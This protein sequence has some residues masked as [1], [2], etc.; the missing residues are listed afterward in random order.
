[1]VGTLLEM[2]DDI[3]YRPLGAYD[4]VL[5]TP[6][7][8]PLAKK[9]DVTLEDIATYGLIL[10]PRHLSSSRIVNLVFEQHHVPY[11]ITLE[12]G[13]WEVIKQFV[14]RGLGI[15]ICASLCLTGAEELVAIPVSRYFPRRNYGLIL[16]KGK[17]V[18][19]A[20][21]R[22][23]DMLADTKFKENPSLNNL[24]HGAASRS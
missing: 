12:A 14:A 10:P 4:P 18:S 9:K 13:G 2:P 22:F 19:P 20:G 5:I 23:I 7:D 21:R 24:R 16:R 8:H 3:E 15:S 6:R 11:Q 17:H 1:M